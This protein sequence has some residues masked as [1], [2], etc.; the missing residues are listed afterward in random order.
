LRASGDLTGFFA[1]LPF[2]ADAKPT[3]LNIV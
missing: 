2:E 1:S 3:L